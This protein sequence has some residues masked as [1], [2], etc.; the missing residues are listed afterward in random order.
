MGYDKV[1]LR[2][3]THQAKFSVRNSAI[4]WFFD[5]QLVENPR[6]RFCKLVWIKV[7]RSFVVFL[8][9]VNLR[10]T[11]A[12]GEPSWLIDTTEALG[13]CLVGHGPTKSWAFLNL[14]FTM[15]SAVIA[16]GSCTAVLREFDIDI[17]LFPTLQEDGNPWS[18]FQ[19]G[20]HPAEIRNRWLIKKIKIKNK[21]DLCDAELP[22]SRLIVSPS[23]R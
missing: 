12:E 5:F 18:G 19:Y 16:P 20:V 8:Q 15:N 10:G 9:E 13:T 4:N 23:S 3:V 21:S 11:S 1:A 6:L 17:L 22:S 2:E 7:Q 14:S